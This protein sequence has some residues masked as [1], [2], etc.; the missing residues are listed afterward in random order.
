VK[1][2]AGR[3]IFFLYIVAAATAIVTVLLTRFGGRPELLERM[4]VEGAPFETATALSLALL[5][6]W[7]LLRRTWY[8]RAFGL[9]LILGA[10]EE[11]SWGQRLLGFETPLWLKGANYQEEANLHNLM[12]SEVFSALVLVPVHI[13]FVYVPLA[14]TLWPR[15]RALPLANRVP[16]QLIPSPH[17]TLIFC[18]GWGLHAWWMPAAAADSAALLVALVLVAFACVRGPAWRA[19][20]VRMHY[21]LVCIATLIFAMSAGIYRYYNMQYEIRELFVVIGFAYWLTAWAGRG[22]FMRLENAEVA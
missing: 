12:D 3:G 21:A 17:T 16:A 6:L 8:W 5:G 14:F 19:Y 15:L 4:T 13:A 2:E 20:G 1:R 10:L 9:L 22:R 11:I 7:C 18:F